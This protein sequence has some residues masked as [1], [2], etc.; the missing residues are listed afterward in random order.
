MKQVSAP[1]FD[2][3][4]W[5]VYA[6]L[7]RRGPRTTFERQP[8]NRCST[9]LTRRSRYKAESN[10][11]GI[12]RSRAFRMSTIDTETLGYGLMKSGT[13]RFNRFIVCCRGDHNPTNSLIL[14]ITHTP[15]ARLD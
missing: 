10:C 12:Y 11:S 3:G 14:Q 8:P 7:R 9:L 1:Q 13:N 15:G 2:S 5:P 4:K 6:M